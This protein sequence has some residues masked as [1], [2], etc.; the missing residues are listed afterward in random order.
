MVAKHLGTQP[1]H[2]S[3]GPNPEH[4]ATSKRIKLGTG[5][6]DKCGPLS[7]LPR[8]RSDD[9]NHDHN[10]T[11]AIIN[12][13]LGV[14]IPLIDSKDISES[15]T[16]PEGHGN[17]EEINDNG[18]DETKEGNNLDDSN[19]DI[20]DII[21]PKQ[22]FKGHEIQGLLSKGDFFGINDE[23]IVSGSDDGRVYFW[24][25]HNGKLVQA[26]NADHRV[27]NCVQRPIY[28]VRQCHPVPFLCTSG[29]DYDIK[30]WEPI[31]GSVTQ[32]SGGGDAALT[33]NAQAQCCEDLH[34]VTKANERIRVENLESQTLISTAH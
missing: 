5:G 7:N 8:S 12:D 21:S 22:S 24:L 13:A 30:V 26:L 15:N 34:D 31:N 4:I 27:V 14:N 32:P 10:R 3:N 9:V 29:I 18:D 19:E 16:P 1:Q 6:W 25:K 11:A 2:E 23:Y 33:L 20:G 17:M 28:A